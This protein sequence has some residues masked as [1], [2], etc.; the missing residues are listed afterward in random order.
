MAVGAAPVLAAPGRLPTLGAPIGRDSRSR[1]V[2]LDDR[3]RTRHVHLLGASGSGKSSIIGGLIKAD[4]E[5]GRGFCL[6]DPHGP[7][8]ELTIAY[9]EQLG[10]V[11]GVDYFVIDSGLEDSDAL[12]VLEGVRGEER[13]DDEIERSVDRFVEAIGAYLGIEMAGRRFEMN[14]RAAAMLVMYASA[15]PTLGEVTRVLLDD[16]HAK[17]LLSQ[18]SN[19][20][21]P[22]VEAVRNFLDQRERADVAN[23]AA[24]KLEPFT[25]RQAVTRLLAPAG[26]GVRFADVMRDNKV[27]IVNLSKG[28]L[29]GRH[30]QLLGHLVLSM[31]IDAGLQRECERAELFSLFID[32]AQSFVPDNMNRG[33]NELRK[34]SVS[35]LISHQHLLQ[36]PLEM[37]ESV[38][39][40][41]GTRIAFRSTPGDAGALA[42]ELAV[43]PH[44]LLGLPDL[45]AYVRLSGQDFGAQAFSLFVDRPAEFFGLSRH[46]DVSGISSIVRTDPMTRAVAPAGGSA[47]TTLG[48]IRQALRSSGVHL[49]SSLVDGTFVGTLNGA[50]GFTRYEA[51]IDDRRVTSRLSAVLPLRAEDRLSALDQLNRWNH[52]EGHVALAFLSSV[53]EMHARLTLERTTAPRQLVSQLPDELAAL[54]EAAHRLRPDS[55]NPP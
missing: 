50:R 23:W 30:S 13:N 12:N 39:G 9:A 31:A 4:L 6:L 44:Q 14:A 11:R 24:S 28:N 15:N 37:R 18:A 49:E 41:A 55:I 47:S 1:T 10:L 42:H 16:E 35:C 53:D 21:K 3:H 51:L 43:L 29:G 26:E 32:E 40:N 19:C 20:P 52:D 17:Q 7:I 33:L 5:V 2:L 46:R 27:L 34:F 36:L 45:Q 25:G 8:A 22:V 38:L 48:A 54:V